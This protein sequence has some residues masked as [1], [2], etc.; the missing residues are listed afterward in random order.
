M[1]SKLWPVVVC[2]WALTWDR[3]HCLLGV[4]SLST[5]HNTQDERS[6]RPWAFRITSG[7]WRL[8][9]VVFIRDNYWI[10][11][12][13][14]SFSARNVLV[15]QVLYIFRAQYTYYGQVELYY[16]VRFSNI[17]QGKLCYSIWSRSTLLL[18]YGILINC[19]MH[20][21][22]VLLTYS[23]SYIGN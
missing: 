22:I 18:W 23:W 17:W 12:N 2:Q 15:A 14:A 21:R 13:A 9:A 19:S 10:Y 7:E 4:G 1:Q 6:N 11:C 3:D 16:L 5:T 8:K 20:K